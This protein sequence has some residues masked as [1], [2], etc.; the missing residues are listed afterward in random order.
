[1]I[2]LDVMVSGA[3]SPALAV[4]MKQSGQ[5][6]PVSQVQ[7]S[8][9]IYD[10]NP[11]VP[12]RNAPAPTSAVSYYPEAPG[13]VR[14]PHLLD[15]NVDFGMN[16][17]VPQ[18][19]TT[20]SDRMVGIDCLVIGWGPT[21]LAT[22]TDS[23]RAPA[24]DPAVAAIQ[25]ALLARGYSVG[26][27]GVDG[28]MGS[29]TIAA[30]RKY[31]ADHNLPVTT[32]IKADARAVLADLASGGHAA[33]TSQP[34]DAGWWVSLATWKKATLVGSGAVGAALVAWAVLR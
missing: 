12:D 6:G 7:S 8:E 28:I 9:N 27:K 20:E 24:S 5:S 3:T 32:D 34:D 29:D 21:Y 17:Y 1:M 25:T 13:F 19:D 14:D 23:S 31:Q 30:I 33:P 4:P 10:T 2:G 11:V 16:R 26:P 18:W 15:I 22:P